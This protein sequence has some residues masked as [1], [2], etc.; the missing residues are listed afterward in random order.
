MDSGESSYYSTEYS[1]DEYSDDYYYGQ[2]EHSRADELPDPEK[3][4]TAIFL[5]EFSAPV[6][7]Q[8]VA[9]GLDPRIVCYPTGMRAIKISK[10]PPT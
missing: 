2:Q 9:T 4:K 10:Y 6:K 1:D 7:V 3:D 8:T 5:G